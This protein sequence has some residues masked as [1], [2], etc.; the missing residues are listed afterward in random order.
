MIMTI[1]EGQVAK[2]NWAI[3][4]QAYKQGAE[5]G[6]RGL[7]RSYLI[8]GLKEPDVWR[9]LTIWSSREALEAMRQS[10]QTPTGVLMFRSANSEPTLS[11][12]DIAQEIVLK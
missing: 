9:I 11:V 7:V 5:R 12:Y 4:E 6:E 8:H 2:E 3:L 10:A 1:L